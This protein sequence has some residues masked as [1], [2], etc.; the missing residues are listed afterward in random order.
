MKT[1]TDP[2]VKIQKALNFLNSRPESH[3]SQIRNIMDVN[4]FNC[5]PPGFSNS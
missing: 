2:E 5:D 1:T 4:P 3:F